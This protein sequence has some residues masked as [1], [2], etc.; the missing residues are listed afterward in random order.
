M[1]MIPNVL[2]PRNYSRQGFVKQIVPIFLYLVFFLTG[3]VNI[4]LSIVATMIENR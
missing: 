3:E 1:P 2:S 4:P